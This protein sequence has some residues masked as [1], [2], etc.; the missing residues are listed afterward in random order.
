MLLT[1]EEITDNLWG[2]FLNL[3]HAVKSMHQV[4]QYLNQV[5]K[6]NFATM[7]LLTYLLARSGIHIYQNRLVYFFYDLFLLSATGP[8]PDPPWSPPP[9]PLLPQE[10]VTAVSPLIDTPEIPLANSR[11]SPTFFLTTPAIIHVTK[12]VTIVLDFP[13]YQP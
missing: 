13:S 8:Q 11:P 3:S 5:A 6:D 12:M 9:S 1:S 4:V 7:T 10:V 2:D